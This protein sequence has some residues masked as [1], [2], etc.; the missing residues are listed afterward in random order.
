VLAWSRH[1]TQAKYR[2]PS[3]ELE[4]LSLG[5]EVTVLDDL[6]PMVVASIDDGEPVLFDPLMVSRRAA[7]GAVQ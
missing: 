3:S 1:A 5:F 4:L 6:G 7:T 2:K